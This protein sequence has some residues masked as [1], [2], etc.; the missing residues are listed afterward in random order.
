MRFIASTAGEPQR[1]VAEARRLVRPGGFVAA[2]EADFATLSCFP[3][4]PAW[5]RLVTAYRACFP[6]TAEDPEAHRIY[7]L[8]RAAGLVE[9]GYRP[10]LV[11]VRAS[12][13]WVDYLPSTVES[14]RPSILARGLLSEAALDAA[15]A[16]C[17]AHLT[18]PDTIFTAP[19]LVQTWGRLPRPD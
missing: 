19:T 3:P 8:L 12:D 4:H 5:T 7:R 10:V 9:V 13:P 1:L 6:W 14:L 17:R 16:A 2:Q 11:G 15:L 18:A